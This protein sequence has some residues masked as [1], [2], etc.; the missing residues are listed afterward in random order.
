MKRISR[1]TG[2]RVSAVI[3]ALGV[4]VAAAI[5][6]TGAAS[7]TAAKPKVAYLSFAVANSYDAPMLAAA[8]KVARA[9]G[10]AVIASSTRPTTRT[11]SSSSCRR[12][13][14]E[15][16]QR[17]HPAADLRARSSSTTVRQAFKAGIKVVNIDQIL[18]TNPGTAAP[19]LAGPV[20]ERRLRPDADRAEA[21]RP[22]RQGVQE[23]RTPARSGTCTRSRFPRSTPRSA[24]ASTRSPRATTSRSSPRA[25][26]FYNPANALK[27]AQTMLQGH[28]DI[29]L[30][31]GADQAATGAE[32]AL[33]GK[34]VTLVGYG[35]GA[36]RPQGASRQ[37]RGTARS[38][39]GPPP[40]ASAVCSA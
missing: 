12:S 35:G 18:G 28:P 22:R 10:A 24:R 19:P 23:A 29:N 37:A 26:T 4:A 36:R 3:V 11:S 17:D 15:A 8:K 39:S 31:V 7:H 30:I 5:G 33:N 27:A 20:G 32:Q 25:Q 16:V 6:A 1:S 21:G 13:S 40:R 34:K 9:Q 14:V 2:R 38:C